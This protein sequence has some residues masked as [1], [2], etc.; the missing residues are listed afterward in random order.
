MSGAWA[1]AQSSYVIGMP[2][3][4]SS[5][6]PCHLARACPATEEAHMD[7]HPPDLLEA[8]THEERMHYI[9]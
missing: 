5:R 2:N 7:G 1:I 6:S 8:C 9:M 3:H 4:R